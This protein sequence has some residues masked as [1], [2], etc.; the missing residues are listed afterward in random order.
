MIKSVQD[1]TIKRC[2]RKDIHTMKN[3]PLYEVRKINNLRDMINSSAE[4]FAERIAFK[5]KK[6]VNEPY[7]N[8]KYKEYI[9]DIDA[10]GTAFLS[11]KL[12]GKRV[13][14]ISENRYEWGMSYLAVVNGIGMIVPIDKELPENEILTCLVRSKVSAVV[15]SG[16]K[17]ESILSLVNKL[18]SV[19]YFID[20]DY[21]GELNYEGVVNFEGSQNINIVSFNDILAKGHELIKN[22]NNQYANLEIN[23]AEPS[24]LLFTSATTSESKAVLLSHK[25]VCENLMAM[26]SMTYIGE[27][28][29]FLSILPIHHTYECTCGFLCP[30]YRG[31]AIAFCD[32]LRYIQKNM[33]EAGVTIVLGVPLVF[34][35]MYKKIWSSAEKGGLANKLRNAIKISNFLRRVGI[36]I[37]RKL[38]KSVYN[39]FSNNLRMF[40]SGA[41]AI[42]P[43][44]SKGFRD[45]GITFIQGYGLTECAPIVALNRNCD[46]KDDA[47]GLP[48]PGLSVK[49]D[50]S[51]DEGIGEII[52]KGPSVMLGYYEQPEETKKAISEEGY[53]RTGDLGYLDNDGF[54]HIT[55]RKKNVIVTKN[56]KNIYPEEI[57][58]LLLRSLLIMECM[59]FGKVDEKDESIVAVSV[60]PDMEY[61]NKTFNIEDISDNR[62]AELIGNEV[63][64]VNKQLTTYKYIKHIDIREKEFAK[65]T[66]RKIKRYLE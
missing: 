57:E 63:R 39:N 42:D 5:S 6:N 28:D 65:T 66:T 7:S 43:L 9:K 26:S 1:L 47:A 22:G 36:D 3:I 38:F 45:L 50:E 54:V 48:L 40:I 46:F 19:E 21:E 20:M 23:S 16:K 31:S 10:L 53:F 8:I 44:V 2:Q 27:D 25:N 24:I 35:S 33:Q 60:L 17:R 62:I 18:N 64:I 51:N 30:L 59:V 12:L 34:E 52:V 4:I 11:M 32:G 29:V 61:I 49:I 37:T 58:T 55:G 15:F 13:A 14:I 41:A 56:G